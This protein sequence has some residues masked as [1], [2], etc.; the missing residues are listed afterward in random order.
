LTGTYPNPTI[1]SGKVLASD[2]ASGAAASNL[3]FPTS[4][5]LSGSYPN[6]TL[7]VSGGP[8]A[9]GQ[10]LTNVSASAALT[11]APG[12]YSDSNSNVATGPTPF[13]SASLS[14]TDNVALGPSMLNNDTTGGDNSAVGV[15]APARPLKA[16]VNSPV[17]TSTSAAQ[18]KKTIP[19]RFAS[20]EETARNRANRTGCSS[21]RR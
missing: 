6:P 14:G 4:G 2:L 11:C 16:A 9:N 10:A 19:T 8:C 1:A 15:D 13:G 18:A 20:V 7:K 5:A 17:A 3:G 21:P 12:V